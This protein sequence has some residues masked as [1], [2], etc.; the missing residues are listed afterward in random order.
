MDQHPGSIFAPPRAGHNC[1]TGVGKPTLTQMPQIQHVYLTEGSQRMAPLKIHLPMGIEAE[2][3]PTDGVECKGGVKNCNRRLCEPPLPHIL[4]K[5]P[6]EIT[7]GIG[8]NNWERLMQVMGRN[9]AYDR[10][11]G[12]SMWHLCRK[13]CCMGQRREIFHCELGGPWSDSTIGWP[14]D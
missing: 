3:S 11:L 2:A 4:L 13:T 12:F 1:D 14:A 7:V 10:T 8:R 6:L 9:G 5:V